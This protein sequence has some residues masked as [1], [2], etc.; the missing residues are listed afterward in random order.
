MRLARRLAAGLLLLVSVAALCADWVA[1]APYEKQFREAPGA[2]PS[3]RFPLG[4]DELGRDRLSRLLH[5][6]RVSLFL[7]CAAALLTTAVAGM[8]GGAA[9]LAGGVWERGLMALTDLC[10]SLPWLFLLISVRAVLPLNVS[11][12]ASVTLTFLLLGLLGWAAPARV[13][14]AGARA[15]RDSDMML[16]ARARGCAPWRLVVMHLAPNLRPVLAAQFLIALPMFIL[17]EANLGLLGL[18]VAEPLPSWGTLLRELED[19]GAVRQN[20]MMLAP[21]ALLLCV[22]AAVHMLSVRRGALE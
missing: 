19:F 16:A 5:G 21:A 14:R 2:P 11:P 22:T 15:L 1:P 18:G 4:T 3:A 12:V 7:A 6:T 8:L 17:A 20:L 13:V 10:L 9:G